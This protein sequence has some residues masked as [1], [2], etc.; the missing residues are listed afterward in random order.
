MTRGFTLVPAAMSHSKAEV[1]V[2][3]KSLDI[4]VSKPLVPA[5]ARE[6]HVTFPTVLVVKLDKHDEVK[7][8]QVKQKGKVQGHKSNIRCRL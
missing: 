8:P 4:C 7:M 1:L 2:R 3:V 6:V 5:E